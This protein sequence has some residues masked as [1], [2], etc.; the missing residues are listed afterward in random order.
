MGYAVDLGDTFAVAVVGW[1]LGTVS[2]ILLYIYATQGGD[3][4]LYKWGA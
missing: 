3:G 4:P 2:A 1:V